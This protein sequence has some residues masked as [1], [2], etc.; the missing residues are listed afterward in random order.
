M[1]NF[2][3]AMSRYRRRKYDDA[4]KF[5]DEILQA[6]HLDQSAWILKCKSLTMK[7]HIDD[8]ELDEEGIGDMLLDENQVNSMARPGTSI[9]R[10]ATSGG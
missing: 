4:I 1:D 7:N 6:N 8:I 3:I 2:V 9:Y 10:P 5:C